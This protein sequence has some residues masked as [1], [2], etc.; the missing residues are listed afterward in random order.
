M[1]ITEFN[2][3]L[4]SIF[5]KVKEEGFKTNDLTKLIF[6]GMSSQISRFIRKGTNFGVKPLSTIS[7]QVEYDLHLVAIKRDDVKSEEIIDMIDK[8]N[9]Q[10]F[11]E[12]HTTTVEYLTDKT[13]NP[14]ARVRN[15]VN[16]VTIDELLS[17]LILQD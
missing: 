14:E 12:L 15:S 5:L 1:Q 6:P 3:N 7:G 11:D 2:D 4:R 13:A 16:K 8:S 10:F 17:D 9:E